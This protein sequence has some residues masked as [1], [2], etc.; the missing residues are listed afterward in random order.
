MK[1]LYLIPFIFLIIQSCN[2]DIDDPKK[3]KEKGKVML[4]LDSYSIPAS[5]IE[6]NISSY[7]A[8]DC[9]LEDVD[10]Y[11]FNSADIKA[12]MVKEK[13]VLNTILDAQKVR[14]EIISLLD[15]ESKIKLTDGTLVKSIEIEIYMLNKFFPTPTTFFGD[16]AST[17]VNAESYLGYSDLSQNYIY[18]HPGEYFVV[19]VCK[20][21][22]YTN[23]V[24]AMDNKDIYSGKF[25]TILD[26]AYSDPKLSIVF[27]MNWNYKGYV[28]WI[29][30]TED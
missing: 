9:L 3:E 11:F 21:F 30:A 1:K 5:Y 6:K 28:D 19:A 2:K 8:K 24:Y 18:L 27:P 29:D 26:K 15:E 25:I 13:L 7:P 16:H 17:R 12:P 23:G 14:P 10:F 20:S 22:K 4:S